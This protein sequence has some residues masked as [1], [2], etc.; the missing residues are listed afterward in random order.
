MPVRI[1]F[2][3]YFPGYILH[4]TPELLLATL[5]TDLHVRVRPLRI[6]LLLATYYLLLTTYYL[7][8]TTYYLLPATY[9]LL[10]TTYYLLLTTYYLQ[11]RI[12]PL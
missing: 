2:L 9:Y 7:L 12:R 10:S 6:N 4:A 5:A 8:L 3:C 1:D 11:L